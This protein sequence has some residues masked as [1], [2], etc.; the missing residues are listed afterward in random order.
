[1]EILLNTKNSKPLVIAEKSLEVFSLNV[2]K[3][4]IR[5]K[6][7]ENIELKLP[8]VKDFFNHFQFILNKT[9]EE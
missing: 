9:K 4:L 7:I 6:N 5:V 1:M 2:W 3:F 8:E